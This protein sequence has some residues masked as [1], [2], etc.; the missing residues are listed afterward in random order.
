MRELNDLVHTV[1]PSLKTYI[2]SCGAV[3][4]LLDSYIDD[5][6]IDIINPV[7]WPAGGHS[8]REWKDKVRGRATLWGG[9]VNAQ[10]TLPLG[11]VEDIRKEAL[12]VI[13]CFAEDGGYVF[14]S[15]HNI[16][17]EIPAE[18]IVA[19]YQTADQV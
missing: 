5:C 12:E 17:A 7:Q 15:I 3:F 14:N 19:L 2:H 9:A 13:R 8:F 4:D 16:L 11:T 18:K 1:A 10:A 6:R